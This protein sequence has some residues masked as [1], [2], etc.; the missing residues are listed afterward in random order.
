MIEFIEKERYYDHSIFTGQCWMYPTFMVKDGK[1]YFMWNRREPDDSWKPEEREHQKAELLANEGKF[2]RFYGFYADP[3]EM[4]TEMESR[5]HTFTDPDDLFVDCTDRSDG[6][7]C[8]FVDFHGNRKEVSAAF[9]YRIYD[10]E[11][12]GRLKERVGLFLTG[13]EDD[14]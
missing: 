8:G 1:E 2:F 12:L 9:R 3:F 10:M 6:Y 14:V 5:G 7:G 11:M 4:L 13:D